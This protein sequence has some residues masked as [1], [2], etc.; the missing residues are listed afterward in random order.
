MAISVIDP[1]T[2][3]VDRT[4]RVLF[5]PFDIVKWLKLGFCAFLAS[6][7]EGGGS[8]NGGGGGERGHGGS[9]GGPELPEHFSDAVAMAWQ[10]LVENPFWAVV[11]AAVLVVLIVI[12]VVLAW[13]KARG[14]FMFLDGVVLNRH[15]AFAPLYQG[16][17]LFV[18]GSSKPTVDHVHHNPVLSQKGRRL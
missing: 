15:D 7:L 10:W 17:Y 2:H 13:L 11:I 16:D 18:N 4:R 5:G 6:L 9:R 8:G 14:K 12:V 3:S 1:I